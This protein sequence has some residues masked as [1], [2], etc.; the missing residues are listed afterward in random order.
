MP[1]NTTLNAGSGG[2]V[3]ATDDIGGTKVQRIKVIHGADG[4]NDGDVAKS[5]P[6]PTAETPFPG[7]TG[8]TAQYTTIQTGTALWTPAAGKKVVITYFQIRVGGVTEGTMQLW[9]GAS[10]DTAYTRGTDLAVFDGEFAPSAT[11]RPLAME[12]GL[13]IASAVDH[14]L[15]VTDSAAINP[16]TVTVWGYEI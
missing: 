1:D 3:I 13:W 6:L 7:L 10:G 5:N 11:L 14:I 15:R 8:K 9:F 4:V 2:D 12:S 16:L